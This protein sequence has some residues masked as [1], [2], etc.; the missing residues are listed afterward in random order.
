MLLIHK[1]TSD[2]TVDFAAQELQK[3]LRMMMPECGDVRIDYAPDAKDGFRLGLMQD[4]SL[5]VS[6]VADTALDDLLYVDTDEHGGIIAGDNPRSVLLAVYEFFRQNGCRWLFPGVDGEKIPMRQIRPVRYRHAPSCRYRGPC[7]EGAISQ[8]L[9]LST[10]DFLPKVGMNVFM[11][12]FF[13]PTVFYTRYYTHARNTVLSPEPVSA[14]TMLQWKTAAESE[15]AKR[16]IEF[17]D[18]GHGFTVAPFGIDVSSG[19]TPIEDTVTEENRK[20]LALL[21]GERTLY[22]GVALN[23]QFCMSSAEARKKVADYVADYAEKHPSAS[24]IHVWLGDSHNNHCE[25]EN[26][27]RETVSDLYVTLLNDIDAVLTARR[28][29]TRIVFI[30]YTETSW[31][32]EHETILH[33]D[34]FTLMLAPISR[35]YTRSMTDS[36]PTL[37]PFRRNHVTLPTDLDAYM[38][39]FDAW[40]KTWKGAALCYE[41]HFWKHQCFDPSG[42]FLAKRIFEDVT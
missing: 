24:Y 40:R 17:H 33:P 6:D 26:C 32:P 36:V 10:I 37:P 23:T 12:Q 4:L 15:M 38:A 34:R 41:Y 8:E 18:V 1:I 30:A 39:H 3:Y 29:G 5:D 28:L 7:I 13:V 21:G 31:A 11:M 2:S 42:L 22:K 35:S 9:L 16:G 19:W 20:Y 25:C 27:A 14:E